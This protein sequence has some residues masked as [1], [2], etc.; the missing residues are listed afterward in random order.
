VITT[1]LRDADAG[2]FAH[3]TGVV[4]ED[5]LRLG[6]SDLRAVVSPERGFGLDVWSMSGA[7]SDGALTVRLMSKGL[8]G[9]DVDLAVWQGYASAPIASQTYRIHGTGVVG[10]AADAQMP[11]V[12][13]LISRCAR[14]GKVVNA[15]PEG[16]EA[17]FEILGC[18]DR[19]Q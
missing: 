9:G 5:G 3:V 7:P 16:L 13:A 14:G 11:K 6:G 19:A 12:G 8:F 10:T 18:A 2:G 15:A 17:A 4:S 1:K